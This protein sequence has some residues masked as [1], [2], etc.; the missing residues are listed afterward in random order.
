MGM[1]VAVRLPGGRWAGRVREPASG[2]RPN[3][4]A[5]VANAQAS[6]RQCTERGSAGHWSGIGHE[7]EARWAVSAKLS[8]AA[9]QACFSALGAPHR[10][11]LFGIDA[12]KL[13][14]VG[15]QP[16]RASRKPGDGR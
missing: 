13:L 16:P 12:I 5:S 7:V 11:L 10:E 14:V 8:A 1:Q 4:P 3:G 15:L 2:P 6:P 9:F